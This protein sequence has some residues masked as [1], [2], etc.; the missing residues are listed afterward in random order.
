MSLRHETRTPGSGTATVVYTLLSHVV[1]AG[2]FDA[3]RQKSSINHTDVK[4]VQNTSFDFDHDRSFAFR[5][6]GTNACYFRIRRAAVCARKCNVRR[7]SFATGHWDR[8]TRRFSTGC[9]RINATVDRTDFD[10]S[11]G[12]PRVYAAVHPVTTRRHVC[13]SVFLTWPNR[14]RTENHL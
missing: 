12:S 11:D 8:R 10:L 6:N 2:G 13:G 1:G 5:A 7:T 4:I 9:R 3:N 14:V